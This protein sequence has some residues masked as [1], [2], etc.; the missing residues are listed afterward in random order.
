MEREK[1]VENLM[2][3]VPYWHYAV[4]KR[5]K[6]LHY[7]KMSRETY[8]CLQMLRHQGA[9]TM[10]EMARRLGISKQQAT[11]TVEELHRHGFLRRVADEHDRRFIRI[12]PTE[13]ANRYIEDNFYR[14]ETMT[15]DLEQSLSPEEIEEFGA[16]IATLRK[17]LPKLA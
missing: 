8:Y 6:R 15:R 1:L 16:A 13:E 17:L 10:S 5:L 2:T 3:V 11:R 14:D 7:N 9:M 12:E 4:N